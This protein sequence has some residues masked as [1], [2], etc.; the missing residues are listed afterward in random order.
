MIFSNRVK[1]RYLQQ[2]NIFLTFSNFSLKFNDV[3]IAGSVD[4]HRPS[5]LTFAVGHFKFF[6]G[7]EIGSLPILEMIQRASVFLSL[8]LRPETF[9]NSSSILSEKDRDSMDPSKISVVSSAYWLI[10]IS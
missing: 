10:L 2:L 8:S 5:A 3:D 7:I 1:R 4:I 9:P 6:P